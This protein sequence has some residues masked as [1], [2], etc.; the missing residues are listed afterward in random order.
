[1]QSKDLEVAAIFC[2]DLHL[3]LNPP[4]YRSKEPDWFAAMSRPLCELRRLQIKHHC[5]VI[6]CGDV[7]DKWKAEPELIN[8]AIAQLPKQFYT[9]AG[10]HD[11]PNHCVEDIHKSALSTLC[12][13]GVACIFNTLN[14]YP[15]APDFILKSAHY[16]QKLIEAS[17]HK[18]SPIN[19]GVIHQY[20]WIPQ[21]GHQKA[22]DKYKVTS[23]RKEFK[24]YDYVFCGD[25][26]IPFYTP[27]KWKHH[28]RMFVNCG[29]MMIRKSDDKFTPTFWLLVSYN[30]K[31]GRTFRIVPYKINIKHDVYWNNPKVKE[32]EQEPSIDDLAKFRQELEKLGE[33]GQDVVAGVKAYVAG[34]PNVSSRTVNFIEKVLYECQNQ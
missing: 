6:C 13:A 8:F 15:F 5:P 22:K 12:L 30:N 17:N 18:E 2:S 1:M 19:I 24:K 10:Q 7:F 4:I 32:K 26:H 31:Q 27:L 14:Y 33:S 20:N 29:A 9:I 21:H 34:L 25:N 11:L 23:R 3:S 16:G 28:I